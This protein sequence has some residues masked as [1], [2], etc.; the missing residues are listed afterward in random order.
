L[1]KYRTRPVEVFYYRGVAYEGLGD[2]VEARKEYLAALALNGRYRPA[3]E[4]VERI[5]E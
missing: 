2:P 1:L 3:R 4:A 5:G